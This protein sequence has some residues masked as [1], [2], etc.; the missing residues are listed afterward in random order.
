M[1]NGRK[2]LEKVLAVIEA[3]HHTRTVLY[4]LEE[5]GRRSKKIVTFLTGLRNELNRLVPE[6]FMQ[7]YDGERMAHLVRYVSAISIRAERGLANFE[8]DRERSKTLIHY[9]ER[10][11]IL[12][13]ALSPMTS[14]EKRKAVEEFFW[15]L[16]E[17]KVSLFAQ[18][19]KTAF[20]VSQKRLNRKLMEI[21][22]MV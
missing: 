21:D 13:K 1:Q 5:T 19:L 9:Q 3:Y 10:L 6:N 11:E 4:H 8:K 2:K 15:L 12:L 14:S 17:Y 16:E 22:K 7:L 18:E 20:P